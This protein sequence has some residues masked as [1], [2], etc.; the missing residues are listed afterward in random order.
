MT[1]SNRWMR[2][3]FAPTDPTTLGFMRIATGV[4]ML[5]V[6]AVYSLD[7][8][9]YFGRYGW[10]S[11]SEVNRERL[12]APSVLAPMFGRD[13][14]ID[15]RPN[16]HVPIFPHRLDA[17]MTFIRNLD[18]DPAKRKEQLAYLVRLHNVALEKANP[19]GKQNPA[20]GL[21]SM[22]PTAVV[23]RDRMRAP[24][25]GL[26]FLG[27]FYTAPKE[28]AAQLDAYEKPAL[29]SPRDRMAPAFLEEVPAAE[30]AVVRREMEAILA[31]L[32]PES[33]QRKYVLDHLVESSLPNRHAFIEFLL[34]LPADAAERTRQINFL[35]KW[36][37]EERKAFRLGNFT[38][39]LWFHISD[40][41]EMA[42]AHGVILFIILLFTLGLFTRV[43]AVLTWLAAVSYIH[44]TQQILFGMDTMMN[45]LLLYL[46]IGNCGAAL[47]LDRLLA[48]RRA[49]RASLGRTG[50]LD[51]ATKA[52]LAAPP[53][54]VA[55]GF[56]LRLTQIHF[57]IIYM[58][59]GMSKLKGASWWNTNAFW[60]TMANPEF[61]L[62]H[63]QWYEHW[64]RWMVQERFVYACMA[65]F[66]VVFTFVM[67]L[68]LPILVWTRLRPYFVVLGCLF[69][70]GISL[71]MGLNIFG[72]FMMTLLLSYLPGCA[73]RSQLRG[74][75]NLARLTVAFDPKRE[76]HL[77][78]AANTAAADLDGQVTFE[79]G[80]G[81]NYTLTIGGTP[82]DPASGTMSSLTLTRAF[83]WLRFVPGVRGLFVPKGV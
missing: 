46:M 38:F 83:G 4:V 67:E 2:F 56:A 57:C 79:P 9:A 68:G 35:E 61:T 40:P 17:V 6:H 49:A 3:W 77:R 41:G 53:K 71:S 10:Y 70:F 23:P 1:G 73:I 78:A 19:P 74:G 76:E 21:V 39:S 59:A 34:D 14:W 69:H 5:Y 54:S 16:A 24:I 45:I 43:T 55:A 82:A 50:T 75:S 27:S 47:S 8:N 65:G 11:L 60:D 18:G 44:R 80:E 28:R 33:T 20:T 52:F 25:E 7:L 48:R 72:L 32:P 62:I 15:Y 37:S 22:D 58:A 26:D 36:N 66:M 42:V 64:L 31:V 29:R 63:F 51:D 12:E 81:K 30:R 13:A